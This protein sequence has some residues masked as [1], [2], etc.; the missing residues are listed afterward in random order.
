MRGAEPGRAAVCG[1]WNG[2]NAGFAQEDG[3][4]RREAERFALEVLLSQEKTGAGVLSEAEVRAESGGEALF[5]LPLARYTGGEAE[6]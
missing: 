4:W 1:R 5:A 6:R 2:R 3:L